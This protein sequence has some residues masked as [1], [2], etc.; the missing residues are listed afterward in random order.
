MSKD[1]RIEL[2][3]VQ[4][5]KNWRCFKKD[6]KFVFYFGM[7]VLVG[8]QGTG[9]SSLLDLLNQ[10]IDR[11]EI[12]EIIT[13]V[14]EYLPTLSFDFEKDNPRKKGYIERGIDVTSRFCSH[15]EI[16]LSVLE[17]LIE[18]VKEEKTRTLV[19][20]DEPESALSLRSIFKLID[21]LDTLVHQGHSIMLST[22]HPYLIES[23]AVV[24]DVGKRR[25]KKGHKF[26]EEMKDNG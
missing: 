4:F 17:V 6:S 25:W 5:L 13:T 20:L 21:I 7:N 18:R 24:F 15:G 19:I 14:P 1:T 22:H 10:K 16:N 8:D 9:K 2:L 11:K 12:A 23:V 26:I 3:T